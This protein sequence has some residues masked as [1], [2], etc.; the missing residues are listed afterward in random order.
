[1][2]CAPVRC[3]AT[4]TLTGRYVT[5]RR[6][7]HLRTALMRFN[8]FL[9]KASVALSS[10]ETEIVAASKAA[11]EAVYLRALFAELGLPQTQPTPL[12]MDK[13]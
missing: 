4:Q 1:M 11:K 9:K 3:E 12:A 2:S 6:D 7:G 8:C 5:P 13:T 10:C